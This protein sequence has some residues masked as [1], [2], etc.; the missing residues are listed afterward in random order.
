[1]STAPAVEIVKATQENVVALRAKVE[2]IEV[3]TAQD[4]VAVCNLVIEGR[5]FI[6]RWQ[7]VFAETIRSAKEHLSIVQ[8]ELKSKVVEAETVVMIAEQKG[9]AYKRAEREAAAREQ[10]RLQQEAQAQARQRAEKERAEAERIAAEQRKA[11]ERELEAQRRAGEIKARE[12]ERLKKQAAQDEVDARTLAAQQAKETAAAV[13]EI[14]IAPNVPKVAG[15]K[16]RINW[17][18][19]IID[20]SKLPRQYLMADEVRIGQFVRETKREGEVIPGVEAYSE[21]GI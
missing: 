5:G 16:A 15:I 21:D 14:R 12:M 4:Y 11:R 2:A 7:G 3:K 18:F 6:K 1:M 9:E 8:N 10:A 19:R 13:P 17:K 20:A